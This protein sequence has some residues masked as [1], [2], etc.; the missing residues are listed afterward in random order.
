MPQAPVQAE[1]PRGV[2][3][4]W[5]LRSADRGGTLTDRLLRARGLWEERDSFLAPNLRDLHDPSL[6]H[7]LDRAAERILRAARGG[8][9]TIIYGDYDVDGITASAILLHTVLA[10]FPSASIA[11]YIPH[12][13]EEG[14]G[15]NPSAIASLAAEGARLI[16]S[17][18]CGITAISPARTAREHGID[19]VI[20]DHHTPSPDALPDALAVVHPRLGGYPFGDLSGSGVAYKLAWRLATLH[21]GRDRVSAPIRTLLLDLMALAALGIIADVVPL[22]GENRILSR[23]GLARMRST[24]LT[25]LRALIEAAGLANARVD[26][27]DVGFRLAPRLNAGGRM[28]HARDALELFTTRDGARAAE[29]SRHLCRLNDE[30]RATEA[31]ILAHAERQALPAIAAG[32]P[33][34]ILADA[35]WHPGVVGIV[36]SR[37][38]DRFARP[39]LLLHHGGEECHGSGRSIDGFDLCSALRACSAHLLSFG[40][41]AMAAGLR[42]KASKLDAFRGA[43]C[44]EAAARL[45]GREL[46]H[47][48]RI[49]AP[50]D[51]AE[52]SA[53]AVADLQRLGP[54]GNS[55]PRPLLRIEDAMIDAPPTPLGTSGKHS[56]FLLRAGDAALR[57]VAWNWSEELAPLR[58][59]M[60]VDAAICPVISTWQGTTRVEGELRDLRILA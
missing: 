57:V 30:R 26:A 6:M 49:D 42:V 34:I 13:L 4:T 43:F 54:F 37:L 16:V 52:L 25:G 53:E 50:A 11:S 33:A 41:H 9:R 56:S 5:M 29:I 7:D 8:E 60:R 12:R 48:L 58:R 17:V 38:V 55:N 27:D 36:C 10:L 39:A 2:R 59:G 47:T 32:A 44:A 45:D 51:L 1:P 15:L 35:D 23:F 20:T 40:G 19:L 22:R 21:E 46:R 24:G 14:Y 28:D 18:D 3:C 31:R